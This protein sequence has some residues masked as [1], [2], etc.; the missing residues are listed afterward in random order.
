MTD[1]QKQAIALLQGPGGDTVDM[2][3]QARAQRDTSSMR[4]AVAPDEVAPEDL[5]SDYSK[6]DPRRTA[7][8]RQDLI[9]TPDARAAIDARAQREDPIKNDPLAGSIVQGLPAGGLAKVIAPIAGPLLSRAIGGAAASPDHPVAGAALGALPGVPGAV[10]SADTSLGEAALEHVTAPTKAPGAMSKVADAVGTAVGGVVGHRVGGPV[11][12]AAG[13]LAGSQAR[14][15]INKAVNSLAQRLAERH[16]VRMASMRAAA[17][18]AAA[19]PTPV[20]EEVTV[21]EKYVPIQKVAE[22][23]VADLEANAPFRQTA[24][25]HAPVQNPMSLE[26][27]L[28][29]SIEIMGDLRVA[30]KTGTVTPDLIQKAIDAGVPQTSVYHIVGN[31]AAAHAA[32]KKAITGE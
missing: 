5:R 4:P 18:E 11:G 29:A 8:G 32:V 15:V 31:R 13:A 21:P 30:A 3:P 10:R 25:P 26:D 28:K 20:A 17:G 27:K 22:Q 9:T 6:R 14:G 7:Q 23:K 1:A 16:M 12:A 24:A 2:G 19:V